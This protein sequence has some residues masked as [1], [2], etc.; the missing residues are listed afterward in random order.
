MT[1]SAEVS[2]IA[3]LQ[4]FVN[5]MKAGD[6]AGA[7][8][9]IA[10]GA[11]LVEAESLPWGGEWRGPDGFAA[12]IGSISTPTEL[13][14]GDAAMIDAGEV[15]VVRVDVEFV[16]RRTGRRLPMTIVEFYTVRDGKI[17][18]GDFYYKDTQAVNEL[19]AN[20]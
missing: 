15:V 7:C 18:G 6:L 10:P 14:V 17:H 9:L 16:S 13:V 20:G 2:A 11:V 4:K 12:L 19:V 8:A 1:T 5:S 3:T